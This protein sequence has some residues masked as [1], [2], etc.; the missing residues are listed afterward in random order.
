MKFLITTRADK[1]I[2]KMTDLTH[3][4]IKKFAE[5]W[6]A[7]FLIL[8]HNA[9]CDVPMGKIHYRIMLFYDLLEEY[10]KIIHLD[11]DV[12]INKNCPNLFNIVPYD[13]IGTIFE[14]RGS[15]QKNRRDRIKEI[16]KKWISI[17]WKTGY[18]NTGVFVVCKSHRKIFR[19]FNGKYWIQKGFDDV[20]L[21]YQINRLGFKIAEFSYQY[22]HMSIFSEPWNESPSRF[23]SYIIHYAGKARFP[24]RGNRTR[25]ELIRDDIKEIY[26]V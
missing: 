15:R 18:I 21:G 10:D 1:N 22:N 5:K 17:G 11:S 14:D 16:Q 6:N 13:Y 24:D 12:V 4:I 3:P 23:N 26:G 8:D 20:H 7:D 19:K 2:K 25:V 9:D